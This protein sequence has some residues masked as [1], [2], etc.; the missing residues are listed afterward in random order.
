MQTRSE[1]QVLRSLQHPNIVQY[2]EA[3]TEAG[4]QYM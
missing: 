2:H 1:V 3:F 4:R